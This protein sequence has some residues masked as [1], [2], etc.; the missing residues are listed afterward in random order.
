MTT[1]YEFNFENELDAEMILSAIG[2][3]MWRYGYVSLVDIY[4]LSGNGTVAT[5]R[6]LTVSWRNINDFK[7]IRVN[8]FGQIKWSIVTSKTEE[9]N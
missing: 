9:P 7:I 6:D 2:E 1:I 3:I 4:D 5:Y 8:N